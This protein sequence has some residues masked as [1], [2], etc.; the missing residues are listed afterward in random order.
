MEQLKASARGG[1]SG[2][3]IVAVG[4]G[5][6]GAGVSMAVANLG[7]FLAQIGKRVVL[8]DADFTGGGLHA[9]LG[10]RRPAVGISDVVAGRVAGIPAA[11]TETPVT[12]LFLLGGA[13]DLLGPTTGEAQIARHL[14]AGMR[15]LEFD[16][17]LVDLPA[18]VN[19]LAIEL[20]AGTDVGIA[21]AVP[22][23][24]AVE[25]TYRFLSA[26]FLHLV[27]N[28]PEADA[29][30]LSV[31]ERL[32]HRDGR[33]PCPREIVAALEGAASPLVARARQLQSLFAP[34]LIVN[35]TRIKIDEELGEA[36]VSAAARWLGFAPRLLGSIGWDDNV[37]LS[38]RRGLPLFI[39]FSRSGACRNLERIVRRFLGQEFKDLS[40]PVAVPPPTAEQN[41]YELLEIYPGA[42]EEDVRRALKRARDWFGPDGLAV[43]GACTDEERQEYQQLA[44]D[45]HG[46]LLDRSRRREYDRSHFP[47]GFRPAAER[48]PRARDSAAGAVTAS[49]DS[50]PE[51]VLESDRIV[52][53]A[54]LGQIRR[55]R[56]VELEDISNRAKISIP[57]L[58]AIE[59]ERFEDLPAPVFVRGFV[60][61]FARYLKVDPGRAVADFMDKYEQARRSP[62]K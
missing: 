62:E 52:D 51:V 50:L 12:G 55:E 45:A 6:G 33:P 8:I 53:G 26:V 9:W 18:G 7:I 41:L 44:A 10:M 13:S 49:R 32:G 34:Q 20:F 11:L 27:R 39:E 46:R 19:T 28:R 24:D 1:A 43:R 36:I 15:A 25:S 56:G 22:T 29:E 16:F 30:S 57:Y 37:W 60:T 5:K 31:L 54:F 17:A 38:L 23:P 58:R 21:V 61:E 3:R 42:S 14:L 59:E 40:T 2:R 4:A 48:A 47:D 35:Q